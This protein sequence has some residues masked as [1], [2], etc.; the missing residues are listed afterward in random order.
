MLNSSFERE[1][2]LTF[3][4]P[5]FFGPNVF[6]SK[7][8]L[9]FMQDLASLGDM[10]LG[11]VSGYRL[12]E[13]IPRYYPDIKIKV[14]SSEE[15]GLI[16]VDQG[17]VD[18]YVGSLYSINLSIKQLNLQA[19]KIN[20]WISIQDKLRIGFTK[21]KTDLVPILRPLKIITLNLISI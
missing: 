14:L 15:E 12:L 4:M 21:S 7:K 3:T 10:T 19:L 18:V 13:E 16:A 1:K 6:V 5:Y 8:G 9:P 2:Y 17:K 20:G 11:V